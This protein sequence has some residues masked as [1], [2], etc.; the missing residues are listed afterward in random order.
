MCRNG[1]EN[2]SKMKRVPC[3]MISEPN[4]PIQMP[5][6]TSHTNNKTSNRVYCIRKKCECG[7]NKINWKRRRVASKD[8]ERRRNVTCLRLKKPLLQC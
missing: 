4:Q 8:G 6:H 2:R 7:L 1:N 3:G 5:T